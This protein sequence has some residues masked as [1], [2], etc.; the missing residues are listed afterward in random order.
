MRNPLTVMKIRPCQYGLAAPL[1]NTFGMVRSNN[2]QAH[3]GWDLDA[4]PGTTVYAITD[5]L[6]KAGISNSYGNWLSLKFSYQGKTYFAFHAHLSGYL[7]SAENQSVTEGAPIAL[8]GRSGNAQN[9]PLGE[10]HLHFEIRTAEFPYG[11]APLTGRIDP[12]EILGYQL[13]S[14]HA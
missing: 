2:T 3:Q 13:Y 6:T 5:G 11:G 8:T 12:G 14:S 4:A 7:T 10:S 1:T 9:I